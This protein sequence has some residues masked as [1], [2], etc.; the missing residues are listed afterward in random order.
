[1]RD[2]DLH[3]RLFKYSCSY[4]IYSPAFD[5]LP[6]EAK[7]YTLRRLF[8]ALNGQAYSRDFDH[9]T[10]EDGRAIREILAATKKDLPAYWHQPLALP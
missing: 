3:T 2:F 4:L 8:D 10:A 9:L 7:E 6:S 1:L 5:A